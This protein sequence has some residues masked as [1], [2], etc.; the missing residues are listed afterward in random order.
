MKIGNHT[1][2]ILLA[3]SV[4]LFLPTLAHAASLYFSPSSGSHAVGSTVTVNIYVSS[5]DQAINAASG[6]VSFP[7]DKLE[8]ISLSKT[9]S[10]FSLWV[11]EPSF[12]NS[13]AAVNF[14]GIAFNPGFTGAS[15]KL[16][17]INFRVKAAGTALLNFFSGSALAND[18]QGTNILTGLGSATFDLGEKIVPIVPEAS[19]QTSPQTSPSSTL[20]APQI[21]SSSH[22]DSDKWY[23]TGEA[24]FTWPVPSDAIAAR[25]LVGKNPQA[26][27]TV[28]YS[29]PVS[30]KEISGLEDGIWYFHVRLQ[31]IAGWSETAHFRF[32]IDTHI[33]K[34]FDIREITRDDPKEPGVKLIFD[35]ED[36]A[37]GIDYYEIQID[38]G[39][40]QIWKDDGSGIFQTP[41]MDPGK[42]L[43]TARAV[44]R[45]GN[46]LASSTEFVVEAL[47]TPVITDYPKE[48][49]SGEPL[50]VEGASL[51]NTRVV[52]WLQGEQEESIKQIVE[53]D[54]SGKF[55]LVYE[56]GLKKGVYDLWAEATDEKGAKS[57]PT[58]KLAVSVTMPVW[59]VIDSWAAGFFAVL[60]P[61]VALFLILVLLWHAWKKLSMYRKSK[62]NLKK[63]VYEAK[64]AFHETLDLLKEDL[65]KQIKELENMD[66]QRRLTREE[67][68]MIIRLKK[69]LDATGKFIKTR[70]RI[71]KKK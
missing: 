20:P 42:H 48:L 8:V 51:T 70:S 55:V 65:H 52:L 4:F 71:L 32:Q 54:E 9:G 39:S 64:H 7:Q 12:S 66:A 43:L 67:N 6:T 30:S 19:P 34:R 29:P 11:Q 25:L 26:V 13:P 59:R 10:I 33:P 31:T 36:E 63:E 60:I 41:A 23:P 15:G 50:F 38:A 24:E 40:P 5:A 16:V 14:E 68:K 35:A 27:P 17:S 37:S 47:E 22:P 57:R 18:G 28:F 3:I 2:K 49:S 62:R 58:E 1:L 46:F 53:T 44:D 21:S 45:A 69:D 56:E 61:L